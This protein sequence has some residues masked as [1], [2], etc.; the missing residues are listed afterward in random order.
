ME[1]ELLHI[2]NQIA[3]IE[4]KATKSENESIM[5]HVDRI[6]SHLEEAGYK[7][8]IPLGERFDET[9]TDC[10][11]NIVGDA[12]KNLIITNVVKPIIIQED[13]GYHIILQK[14]NVIAESI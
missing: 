3:E 14:G 6:K 9:R 8:L 10:T 13:Q 2:I 4:K 1:R 11:A 5:R 7:Y 12:T